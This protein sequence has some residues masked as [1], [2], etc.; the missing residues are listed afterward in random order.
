MFYSTEVNTFGEMN[1]NLVNNISSILK[2][3]GEISKEDKKIM[4]AMIKLLV[5]EVFYETLSF[6]GYDRN[7]RN[8][9]ALSKL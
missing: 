7:K 6:Y 2:K 5:K 1:Q 8:L 3:Y 9:K 4:I